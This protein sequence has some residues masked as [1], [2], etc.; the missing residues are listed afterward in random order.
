[1]SD[2]VHT[3]DGLRCHLAR[4]QAH[5]PRQLQRESL[6]LQDSGRKATLSSPGHPFQ[7]ST[8]PAM[9]HI[10]LCFLHKLLHTQFPAHASSRL[11]TWPLLFSDLFPHSG[12]ALDCRQVCVPGMLK[13]QSGCPRQC[14]WEVSYSG[15]RNEHHR[16]QNY[17]P[18]REQ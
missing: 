18:I 9:H 4:R 12:K 10:A 1:M 15:G 13:T 3:W 8:H 11:T 17:L 7:L 5:G 6:S 14:P 2:T 16:R